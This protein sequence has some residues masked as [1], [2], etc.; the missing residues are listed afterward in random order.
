[1]S[2]FAFLFRNTAAGFREAF[3]TG[4]QAQ[5]SVQAWLDWIRQLD[6]KGLLKDRGQPLE[7]TGKVVRGTRKLISDGPFVESK[8]LVVG[9]LVVE[10][11]DLDH[12]TEIASGCPVLLG[13]GSVEVRPVLQP[14][15]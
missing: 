3:G 5:R 14:V 9:Y 2:N 6:T 10:A 1:M 13:G 4:E 15:A 7:T 8:D 11:R 12:A